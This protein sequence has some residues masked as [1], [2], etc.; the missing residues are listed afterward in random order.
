MI[1]CYFLGCGWIPNR[2]HPLPMLVV[3]YLELNFRVIC[4]VL[5]WAGLTMA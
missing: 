5:R 2:A 3:D 1:Y 4:M